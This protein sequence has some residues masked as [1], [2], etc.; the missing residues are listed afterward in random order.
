MSY[1]WAYEE[2][3]SKMAGTNGPVERKVN[4]A[5][6]TATVVAFVMSLIIMVWPSI[7]DTFST[8]ITAVV[9]A[10]ITGAATWVMAWLTK[11][12][13][14]SDVEAAKGPHKS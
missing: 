2:R 5:G 8:P 7:P 1:A 11:H 4:S 10:A 6:F 12:T 3:K 13:N 9:T 14:R